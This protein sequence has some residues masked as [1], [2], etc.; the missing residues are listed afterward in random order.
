MSVID[1]AKANLAQAKGQL[2]HAFANVPDDRINWSPSP[3]ARTAVQ[4]VAHAADALHHIAEMLDGRPFAVLSIPDADRGFREWESTFTTREE[5][6]AL[7]DK[8]YDAYIALLDRLTPERL[9]SDMIT[10]PFGLGTMPLK[11]GLGAGADHTRWH[12]AQLGYMQT[13]YGDQ[14]WHL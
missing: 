12:A 3:T 2:E 1:E 6:H 11:N 5:V 4:Q 9:E 10:L 7:L 14:D 8:H 13:I